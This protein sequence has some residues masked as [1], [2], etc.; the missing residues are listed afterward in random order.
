MGEGSRG[1]THRTISGLVWTAMGNGGSTVLSFLSLMVMARLVSPREFGTVGA[2]LVVIEFS[3]I[4][5]R[6]GLGPAVIQRQQLEPRHLKAAFAGSLLFGLVTGLVIWFLAPS[7]AT[8]YRNPQVLPVMRVLACVF[9]LKGISAVAESLMYRDLR[10]R[11]MANLDL[12]TLAVSQGLVAIPMAL[13]GYGVWALVGGVLA[14]NLLSSATLLYVRRPTIGLWPERA[15]LGDMMYFGGGFT[16]AKI[17][18]YFALQGDNLV[19]GHWLGP[20]ALGAYER[21]YGIMANPASALGKV[22]DAVLFPTMARVQD[23]VVRLGKAYRRGVAVI[24]LVALPASAVAVVLAPELIRVAL[25]SRWN[26][27]VVPFQ[28]LAAG[29]LFRSSYKMSDSLARTT[30]VVYRRAQRQAIYAALVIGGAF[31]GRYWGITGVAVGVLGALVANFLL[32]AQLSLEVCR[33]TWASFW[34]AHRPSLLVAGAAGVVSWTVATLLRQASAPAL[35]ILGLAGAA[36]CATVLWLMRRYP[37]HC[38][39]SEGMWTIGAMTTFL[40]RSRRPKDPVVT[41]ASVGESA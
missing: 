26:D 34:S 2:A 10:F 35:P 20:V 37:Q 29:T 3:S 21:A 18:N 39:G 28:V 14:Q 32:M 17:A 27:A 40:S 19:V 31:F 11:W 36:S 4:F 1:L 30:G 23:D 13:A 41:G 6:L 16:L 9:P 7:A 12:T 38:L 22:L 25:G 24:A 5:S 8:F 33:L 15:A